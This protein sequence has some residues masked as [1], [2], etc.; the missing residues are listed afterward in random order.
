MARATV[1]AKAATLETKALAADSKSEG[2]RMLMTSG[3]TVSEVAKVFH[4][5][6]GFVYGV[7]KRANLVD[8]AANRR[9]IKAVAPAR[10]IKVASLSK[11]TATAKVAAK[12]AG[13]PK[14]VAAPGRNHIGR[15]SNAERVAEAR[16]KHTKIPA[17]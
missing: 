14:R 3:R 16:A 4:A 8:Q 7:A 2:M 13:Q 6:Y 9:P 10:H 5:P 11:A 12:L 1:T 17:R 15:P